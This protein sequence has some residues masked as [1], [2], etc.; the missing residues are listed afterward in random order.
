MSDMRFSTTPDLHLPRLQR[1]VLL[2]AGGIAASGAGSWLVLEGFA[3]PSDEVAAVPFCLGI[4]LALFALT[5][6]VQGF[7]GARRRGE[8]AIDVVYEPDGLRTRGGR[9]TP[10]DSIREVVVIQYKNNAKVQLLWDN[11]ALNTAVEVALRDRAELDGLGR[12]GTRWRRGERRLY[13]D[14]RRYSREERGGDFNDIVGR[15]KS[16]RI[17]VNFKHAHQQV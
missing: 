16:R 7:R 17:T 12:A 2:F 13:I 8:N 15:L 14:L 6:F 5:G 3:D 1:S 10:W 9:L 11:S 4:L